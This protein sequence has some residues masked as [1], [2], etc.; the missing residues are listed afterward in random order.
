MYEIQIYP[1]F[2]NNAEEKNRK[3]LEAIKLYV[4]LTKQ[5]YS[6]IKFE[7]DSFIQ[8]VDLFRIAPEL[9]L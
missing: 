9:L 3:L 8:F 2:Q 5:A 4:G 6:K 1:E 7:E